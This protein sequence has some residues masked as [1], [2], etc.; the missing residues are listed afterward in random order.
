MYE[1]FPF[2]PSKTHTVITVGKYRALL[3]EE[4]RERCHC[5]F[6]TV[7]CNVFRQTTLAKFGKSVSA[8]LLT[9]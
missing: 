3:T 2:V 7:V 6:I 9:P 4:K 8:W 1:L 5:L